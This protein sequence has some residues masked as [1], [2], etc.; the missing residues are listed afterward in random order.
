MSVLTRHPWGWGMAA[1]ILGTLATLQPGLRVPLPPPLTTIDPASVSRMAIAHRRGTGIRLER[2]HDRWWLI[3]PR[4]ALARPERVATL[5]RWL[6]APAGQCYPVAG[7]VLN[8]MQ[9]TPPLYRLEIDGQWLDLGGTDPIAGDRYVLKG[10][11]VCLAADWLLPHLVATP[12][13]W[14][15]R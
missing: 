10:E 8:D 15:V 7:L 3:H 1:A 2:R 14:E 5:L 6:T 13:D 9:L 4:E 11:Q 12:A